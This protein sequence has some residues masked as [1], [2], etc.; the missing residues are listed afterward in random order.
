MKKKKYLITAYPYCVQY[1]TITVP[2]DDDILI[3]LK[4]YIIDHFHE[5]KFEEPELDYCGTDFEYEEE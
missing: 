3:N 5:I 4:D 2:D 1:G